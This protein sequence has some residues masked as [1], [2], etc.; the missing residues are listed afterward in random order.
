M[1]SLIKS[2]VAVSLFASL[3]S[4][5]LAQ[6]VIYRETFG[7]KAGNN[8]LSALSANINSWNAYE[9]TVSSATTRGVVSNGAGASTT[10][11]NAGTG[12]SSLS[13]TNG[14]VYTETINIPYLVVT[15]AL[16]LNQSQYSGITFTWDAKNNNAASTQRIAV[17]IGGNWYVSAQTFS[18]STNTWTAQSFSFTNTSTAW[19][20][21]TAQISSNKLPDSVAATS[22]TSALPTGNIT[23][24]GLYLGKFNDTQRIDTFAITATAIPEP[25][26][27]AILSGVT[28][29]GLAGMTRRRPRK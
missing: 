21:L 20:D 11:D 29:L 14:F 16:T 12:F 3:A 6:S 18:T 26:T 28:A 19:I 10:L 15:T 4:L 25:S 8:S 13:L 1:K 27:F 23:S 22:L 24:F 5:S 9:T 2:F 17:Q 7:N